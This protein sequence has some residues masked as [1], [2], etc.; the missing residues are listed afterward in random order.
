MEEQNYIAFEN[1]LSK[2]LSEA[3]IV[4]FEN[5]LDTDNKF[6]EAFNTYKELSSFL[7][8]TYKNEAESTA[9]KNNLKSISNKHFN[10]KVVVLEEKE[11]TKTLNLFKYALVACILLMFGIFTFN[12]FSNP[13][14][15]DYNNYN[16][17]S[18]TVRGNNNA[19]LQT[20]EKAF[21]NKN[22]ELA[23]ETFN[24]L[25]ALDHNNSELKLYSAISN[26]ELNNFNISDD[27]L[28]DLSQGNSAYK[29]KAIWYLALSKLKQNDK[30]A[31]LKLL[32]TI[33]KDADD[34]KKAQKLMNKLD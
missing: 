29:N 8:N 30:M 15:S 6:T 24:Q 34:Y 25:I 10:N 32:K 33:T 4:A 22:F 12:Q 21:N 17:I 28:V 9:F 14:Y 20:A 5:K 11:S 16:A 19:L 1:Y 13:V 7:S 3:E 31:C 27:L 18:L 2:N 23:N 26:I